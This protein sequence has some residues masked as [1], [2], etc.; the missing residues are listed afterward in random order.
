[1]LKLLYRAR[2]KVFSWYLWALALAVI[3]GWV[4]LELVQYH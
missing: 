4:P 3:V 1:V 2:L